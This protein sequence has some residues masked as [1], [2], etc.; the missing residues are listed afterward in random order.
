M[1]TAW[2]K[3]RGQ[4]LYLSRSFRLVWNSAPTWTLAWLALLIIQGLLPAASVYL[5]RALVNSIV[6][7]IE[8]DA[9]PETVR[10]ALLLATT[11]G[12]LLAGIEILRGISNWVRTALSEQ[13]R[14]AIAD[15]VH[16]QSL[17]VD[18]A[19]YD[20]PEYYDHQYR[21]GQEAGYRPVALL[22]NFGALLQNGITLAAMMIVL[23]PYG[24]WLPLVL[25][26]ST[27]PALYVV[28]RNAR[29]RH[30]WQRQVTADERRSWYYDWLITT[31][32][33]AAEIRLFGLGQQFR[34]NYQDVRAR[35]RDGRMVLVRHEGVAEMIAGVIALLAVGGTM[36]LMLWRV[37]QGM[38][39][40]GDIAL[41][42]QAFTQGQS[43]MRT[44]LQ[45]VG[46]IYGNSLFL[47]DLFDFLSL[48]PGVGDPKEPAEINL[49]GDV[50]IEF[51]NVSFAYPGSKQR[52]LDDFC[53]TVKTGQTIA[54]VGSNG[55]GKSTFV[56]LL[57]R[58]YDPTYGSVS[59]FGQDLR[60]LAQ[61]D[62]R[63]QLSVLFQTPVQFNSTVAETIALGDLQSDSSRKAIEEAAYFAGADDIV[64]RL[65]GGY[66]TL[67]GVWFLDGTDLS[68]GEWRRIALARVLLRPS[69]LMVLD[70][71]TSAMDPWAESEWL[72]R[73]RAYAQGRTVIVIT[74]R[75]STAMHADMIYVMEAGKIVESGTHEELLAWQGRYARSWQEQVNPSTGGWTAEFEAINEC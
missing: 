58:F 34:N 24:W 73:F 38:L 39:T 44:L 8:S 29:W 42:Y 68:V 13:V 43:L 31:R 53:L 16:E 37:L 32:E 20:L 19:F 45:S 36:L 27:L 2:R 14:D 5:T 69:P 7:A 26:A 41:I 50:A 10:L 75:F 35:L 30:A 66:E 22:E 47:G 40:L 15:L 46:Q 72:R 1:S 3:L 18:L 62:L 6:A 63:R 9:A 55:A 28:L 59:W 4:L 11:M 60:D 23:L 12:L 51:K 74:H 49:S 56:K 61:D 54:I 25:L 33:N 70:E 65:P 52:S 17:A 64:D 48:E 71:P 67:L 57:C 21:A